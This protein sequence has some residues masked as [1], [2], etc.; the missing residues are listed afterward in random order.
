MEVCE[1][2]VRDYNGELIPQLPTAFA[3]DLMTYSTSHGENQAMADVISFFCMMTGLEIAPNKMVAR[4]LN[5][6]HQQ[7]SDGAYLS[8]WTINGERAQV[9]IQDASEPGE[10]S[11]DLLRYLVIYVEQDLSWNGQ[12]SIIQDKIETLVRVLGSSRA[13]SHIKWYAMAM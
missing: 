1:S 9:G 5:I 13:S 10:Q 12:M 4:S 2:T 3:D 11:K 8:I 6:P 7:R